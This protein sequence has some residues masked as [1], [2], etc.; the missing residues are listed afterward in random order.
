M[1]RK[2]EHKGIH[3]HNNEGGSPCQIILVALSLVLSVQARAGPLDLFR[4]YTETR[5]PIVLLHALF[6]TD[7]TAVYRQQANRLRNKGP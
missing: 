7:P 4:G 3:R 1:I 2:A 6:E 5:H